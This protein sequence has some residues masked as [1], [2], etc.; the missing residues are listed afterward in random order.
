M[1]SMTFGI[2]ANFPGTPNLVL[3]GSIFVL[4]S[5]HERP[6]SIVGSKA[7]ESGDGQELRESQLVRG[8]RAYNYQLGAFVVGAWAF[9]GAYL[10][11][12][13]SIFRWIMYKDL[14][15]G[16]YFTMS[17]RMILAVFVAIAVYHLT[18]GGE[19]QGKEHAGSQI[20]LV[21][22]A[23]GFMI[24]M[25]PSKG[26]K[27]IQEN[28]DVFIRTKPSE[29]L[30]LDLIQGITD[31]SKEWL[32]AL[33]IDNS[34]NLARTPLELL[35]LNSPLAEEMLIDWKGQALLHTYF[36]SL[37]TIDRLQKSGNCSPLCA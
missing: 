35:R 4:S 14:S 18:G 1:W 34:Q 16:A 25:F 28:V 23:I 3:G 30:P 20:D 11:C 7:T 19:I 22:P 27:L 8:S 29:R 15:A 37:Y 33:G 10:W 12:I 24:G 2:E 36:S 32:N 17:I 26:I 13:Q 21:W 9:L 5:E 6:Q 31:F